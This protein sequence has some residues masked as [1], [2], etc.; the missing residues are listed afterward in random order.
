MSFFRAWDCL[1]SSIWTQGCRSGIP[2]CYEM[3][4]GSFDCKSSWLSPK[5]PWQV[6]T[7]VER[8]KPWLICLKGYTKSAEST[9]RCLNSRKSF[10][11]A[12]GDVLLT[13]LGLMVSDGVAYT[14]G[15]GERAITLGGAT[16]AGLEGLKGFLGAFLTAFL[17]ETVRRV[18]TAIIQIK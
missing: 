16:L 1:L 8:K 13:R 4:Q 5:P 10:W 18:P 14:W 7:K 11:L 15:T 3:Y 9:R 2:P 12:S 17:L 6:P